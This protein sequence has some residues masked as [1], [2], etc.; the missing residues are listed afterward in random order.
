M[1]IEDGSVTVMDFSGVVHDDDLSDETDGFSC[2][3]I[4]GIRTNV[5]SLELFNGKI[6][7]IE[8]YVISWVGLG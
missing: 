5:T 6:L 1:A 8:S 4:L 2:G 3:V 7:N